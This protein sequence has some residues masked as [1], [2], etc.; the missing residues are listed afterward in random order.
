MPDL[1]ITVRFHDG[2]YHGAGPWPP[3]PAR[4]FQ[5]LVAGAAC[6]ATLAPAD[7]RALAWL[8]TLPP[9]DIAAPPAGKGRSF[10]T[11]VPNNDLDAVG[12]DPARISKIRVG[13]SVR[14]MLFDAGTPLLYRWRLGEDAAGH[15]RTVIAIADRLYQL[16]RGV[17]MAW[18]SAE[19]LDAETADARL[20]AHGGAI[21]RPS[22]GAGG[23]ALAC[24]LKGS[25][26]SLILRHRA[27]GERFR[28]EGKGKN[29]QLLF[30]QPP[31]PRFR[32]VAYDCP[33]ARLLFDLR[34]SAGNAGFHAWPLTGIVTL[35]ETV[36]DHAA[37]RLAVAL[38][39]RAACIGRVFGRVPDLS[40]ADK[41]RRLRI[42]PLPSIGHRH[43]EPSIRRVLVEVPPD[44]PLPLGD[45]EWAFSGLDLGCDPESGEVLDGALPMLVRADDWRMPGHYGI[46]QDDAQTRRLWRTVTPAALPARA[47]RRRIDP[48]RTGPEAKG[49]SERLAE[50]ARAVGAV[51]Q[52]LRHAGIATPVE[53]IRVQ[54][55]PFHAR[56]SRA[57]AFARDTRFSAHCLWH[58]EIAFAERHDGAVIIGDGR[59]LGLGLME[60]GPGAFREAAVFT[61]EGDAPPAAARAGILAA[62]R[63]ALMALDRDRNGEVSTLFSGHGAD[64]AP[65]GD[66]THEHVF[67]A[68][69][70]DPDGA[71]LTRLHV[72]RPDAA[73][74]RT[75][76]S[77]DMRARFERVT[78]MLE[79]LRAGPHGVLRLAG[80][81]APGPDDRLFALARVWT[82][83]TD[84][85]PTRHP[86]GAADV[87]AFIARDV[88]AE[89]LR[90]GY[91]EPDVEVLSR[92]IGPRG[93][94]RARLRL[95]FAV[96]VDG[97]LVLGR[98]S[99]AGGGLFAAV[100]G[101]GNAGG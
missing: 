101:D 11:Y 76:L 78:E 27:T 60:P 16:G 18:A 67:L 89:L 2:R 23:T 51:A 32:Q 62:L 57:E 7:A 1:L 25:L 86:R 44:C 48:A 33:P 22:D 83:L 41:A 61:I 8:E 46:G 10:T 58:V 34:A 84:F 30:V 36:R 37:A 12:G 64:G 56:G 87:D 55:E 100:N 91:P 99:H 94:I 95:T 14:P 39:D 15:A 63:R 49:A 42:T 40:E 69:D 88:R 50:E 65:A 17:D 4:L 47:A 21:H 5:A 85:R 93:A 9:P 31:R 24:P 68:A 26:D 3:S 74:R 28:R 38:P 81:A 45:L 72:I 80:P 77:R 59:W 52:A 29:T 35:A 90:R 20:E 82:S 96:A 92:G 97:P 75:G 79:T 19:C 53:F 73:D 70:T 66:G 71:R 54:R 6:G 43:A 13:K 98:D